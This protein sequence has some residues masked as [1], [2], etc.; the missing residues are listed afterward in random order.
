MNKREI[1]RF[2]E[3]GEVLQVSDIK[4]G[5]VTL[6]VPECYRGA[7]E[8]CSS[9]RSIDTFE[10]LY[11]IVYKTSAIRCDIV[12]ILYDSFNHHSLSG[13]EAGRFIVAYFIVAAVAIVTI[14]SY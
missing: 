14:F 9:V 2:T 5:K 8:F 10:N 3:V 1:K 6:L 4:N 13:E 12:I 7:K 11:K